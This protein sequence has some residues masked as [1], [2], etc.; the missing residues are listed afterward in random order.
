AGQP[1]GVIRPLQ[2]VS[3]SPLP[4]DNSHPDLTAQEHQL[5][6][7]IV[8]THDVDCSGTS[9]IDGLGPNAI[10]RNWNADPNDPASYNFA[11]TDRAVLSIA[12]SGATIE[13]SVGRSDLSSAGVGF[14]NTP[15]P[16]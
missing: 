11:P 15:P 13:Y 12:R 7:N 4:G 10:F 2:G 8:R 9:D 1:T 5:G 3:G 6:V 16:D 14:N